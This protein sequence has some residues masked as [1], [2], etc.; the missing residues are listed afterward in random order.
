MRATALISTV[1]LTGLAIGPTVGGLILAV[2]PWQALL[3]INVP[4][5]I[6]AAC[7]IRF[8]I[9]ADHP[10][11]LH[12]APLDLIGALLGTATIT[13]AL[14]AATLAVGDGWNT[15]TPWLV[16]V[17]ALVCGAGFVIR[18]RYAKNPMLDFALL[19][20]PSSPPGS[21]T[22]PPSGS[23]SRSSATA[24]PSNSNSS[25]AGHPPSPRSATCPKSSP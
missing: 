3:V 17:G 13:L 6:L 16:G 8:G 25:G 12:R 11:E 9:R 5:A 1:G 23:G 15:P 14:W 20:R 22:R 7:C 10:A 19:K 21:R 24:S 4:I 2:W 18:E